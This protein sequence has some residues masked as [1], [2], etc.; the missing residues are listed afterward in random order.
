MGK[1]ASVAQLLPSCGGV[2]HHQ[3]S[4]FQVYDWYFGT[5][6]IRTAAM[7]SEYKIS[8]VYYT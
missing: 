6:C 2:Y 1:D 8:I 4:N 5:L 7:I 3:H